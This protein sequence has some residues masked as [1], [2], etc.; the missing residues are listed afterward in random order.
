MSDFSNYEK[1]LDTIVFLMFA[2]IGVLIGCV[3]WWFNL[4]FESLIAVTVWIGLWAWL[5]KAKRS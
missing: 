4:W 3:M 2:A 5:I 1:E